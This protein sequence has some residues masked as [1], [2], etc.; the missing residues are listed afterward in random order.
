MSGFLQQLYKM[1]GLSQRDIDRLEHLLQKR[2]DI[3]NET[4]DYDETLKVKINMQRANL[5]GANLIGANLIGADLGGAHLRGAHLRGANLM[6]ANFRYFDARL[7]NLYGEDDEIGTNLTGGADLKDANLMGANLRGANLMGANLIDA[8]L[9]GADLRGA[10]LRGA[11][12]IGANLFD[13][14]LTDA[15]LTDANLFG[16]NLTGANLTGA[17]LTDANLTGANLTGATLIRQPI[18]GEHRGQAYEIHNAFLEFKSK[19]ARFLDIIN[20]ENNPNIYNRDSIYQYIYRVF[21]ENII[22]L[23]PSQPEQQEKKEMFERVFKKIQH[24]IHTEHIELVGKSI[25]FAFSQNDDFIKEYIISFLHD[26]CNAYTTGDTMS[27]TKGIIERF[28][29]TIGTVVEILCKKECNNEVYQQLYDLL[30]G[31]IDYQ[32]AMQSWFENAKDD[33]NIKNMTV[34]QKKA[35]FI[36]YMTENTALSPERI[37][38]LATEMEYAFDDFTLGGGNML[39]QRKKTR[40]SKKSRKTKRSRKSK[41]SIKK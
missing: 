21:S 24:H 40:K 26:T 5:R 38:Q 36:A 25:H 32:T 16:A 17:N 34:P 12:L 8:D 28:A 41:K 3:Y 18:I 7:I 39:R 35:N 22:K 15:N 4:N 19:I 13:A 29:L 33:E 10:N 37:N 27:C 14:I 9:T 2:Q 31:K 20:E 23:F 6:G 30:V 1:S 11:K